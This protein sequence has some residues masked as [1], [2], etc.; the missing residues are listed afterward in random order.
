MRDVVE[1][2]AVKT[3]SM[4]AIV[5]NSLSAPYDDPCQWKFVAYEE[6][7]LE[8]HWYKDIAVNQEDVCASIRKIP[9]ST[10][11]LNYYSAIAKGHLTDDGGKI[12]VM[13]CKDMD[14]E[15][16]S[17]IQ[18]SRNVFSGFRYEWQ[19]RGGT[20]HD[21]TTHKR[22]VVVP[23]EPLAG[24]LRHP[25][26]CEVEYMPRK[27]YMVLDGWA[28]HN[29]GILNTNQ[30]IFRK[31]FYFD[32]GASLWESGSGGASQSWFYKSYH[33]LCVNF[34]HIYAWEAQTLPPALAFE[35]IPGEVRA[36]YHWFNIPA[37]TGEGD[38][39]NPLTI[40][41]SETVPSDFVVLKIDVD[42]WQVEEEL[43][44]QII[45]SSEIYSRIDEM[46][47]EHHAQIGPMQHLWGKQVHQGMSMNNSIALF[48]KMR[49]RGIRLH[50]WV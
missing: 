40:I 34:D 6:S 31:N 32:I 26:G 49:E 43:V 5:V 46:F 25:R 28:I 35:Q 36:K 33:N 44:R 15:F 10:W 2:Q 14:A 29:V 18:L 22:S 13:H 8:S 16:D 1:N 48:R 27:D 41:L 3:G 30:R 17:P 38:W 19:C 45:E 47:W 20:K 4:S 39:N 50:S 24:L 23:I 9:Y 7:A 37:A 11:F 12:S 42:N 21:A